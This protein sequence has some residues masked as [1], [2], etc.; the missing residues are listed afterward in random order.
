M[1]PEQIRDARTFL[2]AW[3]SL[4]SHAVDHKRGGQA[5]E[6]IRTLLDIIEG[7]HQRIATICDEACGLQPVQDAEASLSMIERKLDELRRLWL[8]LDTGVRAIVADDSLT[9]GQVRAQ[10]AR[11]LGGL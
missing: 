1:T 2:D 3:S 5:I 6:V 7:D 9:S 11:L 10:L 8:N 4:A